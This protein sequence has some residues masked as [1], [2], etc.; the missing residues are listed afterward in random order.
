MLRSSIRNLSVDH[1]LR[2]LILGQ[3]SGRIDY[4][5]A[6]LRW[7]W[8]RGRNFLRDGGVRRFRFRSFYRW[9]RRGFR[10]RSWSFGRIARLGRRSVFRRRLSSAAGRT[11]VFR[12]SCRN[13]RL[14]G[15]AFRRRSGRLVNF[16]GS[17][18][19]RALNGSLRFASSGLIF[20]NRCGGLRFGNSSDGIDR[21][22]RDDNSDAR[23]LL[24]GRYLRVDFGGLRRSL[25]GS[26]WR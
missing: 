23:R 1:R 20:R 14:F 3:R 25:A 10:G 17:S 16:D 12:C 6:R 19:R 18:R 11:R 22:L 21:L 9:W 24:V 2:R 15:F 13:R 5:I 8:R 4:F 7:L 26:S